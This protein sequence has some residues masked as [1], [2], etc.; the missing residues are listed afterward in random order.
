MSVGNERLF[1]L[2]DAKAKESSLWI[3]LGQIWH[4]F[5]PLSFDAKKE[6]LMVR[7]GGADLV[8][9]FHIPKVHD[10]TSTVALSKGSYRLVDGTIV[11]SADAKLRLHGNII[12]SP[13]GV[14]VSDGGQSIVAGDLEIERPNGVLRIS[15]GI[16]TSKDGATEISGSG[17]TF[18]ANDGTVFNGSHMILYS[19][20]G[21][22]NGPPNSAAAPPSPAQSAHQP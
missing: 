19:Q 16:V 1:V 4:G 12:S 18:T 10:V 6:K 15:N 11:Y 9:D 7:R 8:L 5:T 13:N 3:K 22:V 17:I 21:N 14:M 20:P 2:F